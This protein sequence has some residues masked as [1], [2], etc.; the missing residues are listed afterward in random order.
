MSKTDLNRAAII[1]A[2]VDFINFRINTSNPPQ[3]AWTR[4]SIVSAIDGRLGFNKLLVVTAELMEEIA[5]TV[6]GTYVTNKK[7]NYKIVV[8]V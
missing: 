1:N 4:D 2:A 7:G 3:R 6:G 8:P 5:T